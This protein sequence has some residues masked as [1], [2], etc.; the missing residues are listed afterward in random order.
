VL[1][2][3]CAYLSHAPGSAS[4][5]ISIIYM[6]YL[7]GVAVSVLRWLAQWKRYRFR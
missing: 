6:T 4:P 2:G 5:L 3:S 1:I 7:L